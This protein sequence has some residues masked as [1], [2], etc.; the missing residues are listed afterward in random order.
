MAANTQ[1]AKKLGQRVP[2]GEPGLRP[3]ARS[4]VQGVAAPLFMLVPLPGGPSPPGAE[5]LNLPIKNTDS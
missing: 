1:E 2:V 4:K 5:F 3:R